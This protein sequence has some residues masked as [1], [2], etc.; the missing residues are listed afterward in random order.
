[1]SMYRLIAHVVVCSGLY[2]TSCQVPRW[3]TRLY[4]P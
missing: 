2:S 4:F 1:M 3:T